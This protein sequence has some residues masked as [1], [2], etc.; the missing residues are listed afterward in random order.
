MRRDFLSAELMSASLIISIIIA[1][2][3]ILISLHAAPIV[4]AATKS[5][6]VVVPMS[7]NAA[8]KRDRLDIKINHGTN[9]MPTSAV[10]AGTKIPVGCDG[11]FSK[12]VRLESIAVRCVTSLETVVKFTQATDPHRAL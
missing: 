3:T 7:S 6:E 11:A 9:S 5:V 1:W 8:R 12:L 4:G 10:K 2:M